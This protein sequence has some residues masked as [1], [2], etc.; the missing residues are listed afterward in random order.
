M[1][2]PVDDDSRASRPRARCSPGSRTPTEPGSIAGSLDAARENARRARETVSTELWECAEHDP[3]RPRPRQV[4]DPQPAPSIF[5]WV[6]ERVA[7]VTG[8][9][10]ATMSRD[11]VWH[12]LCSADRSS[13]PT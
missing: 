10:D 12:F 2:A 6:R 13:G 8:I 7:A 1:G 3:Q 9:A 5:A 4:V 11:E